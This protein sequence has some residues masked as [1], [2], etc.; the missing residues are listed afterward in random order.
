MF[1]ASPT[2]KQVWPNRAACWSPR[3]PAT[4]MPASSPL[5]SPYTSLDGLICGSMALGTPSVFRML[6]SQ[7]R[8]FRSMSKVRLALLTSV[9][10]RPPLVPPVRFQM[11]QVSMLPNST[12]PRS[13]RSRTP[14]TLSRIHL[15][16][17]PEK[18]V[19]MGRPVVG[20]KRSSPPCFISSLQIWSVRV[21]C[22]TMAL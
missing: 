4:G 14:S 13:A 18:Y 9:M 11:H 10:C 19:A 6:S 7:S 2:E 15:I 5:A 3:S 12:S 8:V 22:Q 20:R 17:G 16:L 21:S 1:L